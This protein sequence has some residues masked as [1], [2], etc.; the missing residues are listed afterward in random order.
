MNVEFAGTTGRTLPRQR[1]AALYAEIQQ[2]YG[3]QMEILDA[4]DTERWADLCTEDAVF[5]LPSLPEPLSVRDGLD[6]YVRAGAERQRRAGVRI[7]HWVGMLDVHPRADGALHTRC[8]A[9]VC[10]ARSGGDAKVL[11]VYAMEDVLVRASGG[12][13]IAH[14]R[15]T[16]DDLA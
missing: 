11:Y 16:R 14:R 8:S 9:L 7:A 13:R 1:F 2:F 15:V 12:W 5:E 3:R 4:H 10:P 6:P